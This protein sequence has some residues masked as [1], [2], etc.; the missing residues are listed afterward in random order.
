MN[1]KVTL[2][3]IYGWFW[4]MNFSPGEKL[5]CSR[6][7]S[8]P[9]WQTNRKASSWF[10][11]GNRCL[12]RLKSQHVWLFGTLMIFQGHKSKAV[13]NLGAEWFPLAAE[14]AVMHVSHH[15]KCWRWLDQNQSWKWRIEATKLHFFFFPFFF[16][17]RTPTST[18]QRFTLLGLSGGCSCFAD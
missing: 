12:K 5:S 9:A 1:L 7:S 15:T 16:I 8:C 17:T 3:L 2:L 18:F 10:A 14:N 4:K 11:L 6:S 13:R